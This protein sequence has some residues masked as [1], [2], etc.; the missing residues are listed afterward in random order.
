MALQAIHLPLRSQITDD[1]RPGREFD[2]FDTDARE[3]L[4]QDLLYAFRNGLDSSELEAMER[5]ISEENR[6]NGDMTLAVLEQRIAQVEN[7]PFYRRDAFQDGTQFDAWQKR[8]LALARRL[9]EEGKKNRS[10]GKVLLQLRVRQFKI[11]RRKLKGKSTSHW[12]RYRCIGRI[13]CAMSDT[14]DLRPGPSVFYYVHSRKNSVKPRK[15]SP[16]VDG[17]PH[18]TVDEFSQD[19]ISQ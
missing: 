16:P 11:D 13:S 12:L 9:L 8:E 14:G 2:C 18:V 4:V 10:D 17:T 3:A 5:S 7:H 6:T 19:I 1:C 15:I